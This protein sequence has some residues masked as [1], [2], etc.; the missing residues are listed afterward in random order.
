MRCVL[1]GHRYRLPDPGTARCARC[2]FFAMR[3]ARS[4]AEADALASMNR[5]I[6]GI[7]TAIEG[8]AAAMGEAI[9]AFNGVGRALSDVALSH[10]AATGRHW[11]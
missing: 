8:V 5:Q 10:Y 1:I 3:S 6:A 11:P 2:G 9:A 4:R 7:G